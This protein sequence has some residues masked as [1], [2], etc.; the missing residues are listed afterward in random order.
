MCTLTPALPISVV[1]ENLRKQ[2]ISERDIRGLMNDEE[3]KSKLY[4]N[5]Q[6][7]Y[8]YDYYVEQLN[9]NI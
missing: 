7:C 2:N 4:K 1:E 6:L 5:H 8:F 9:K 3:F